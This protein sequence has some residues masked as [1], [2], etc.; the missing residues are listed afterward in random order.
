MPSFTLFRNHRYAWGLAAS[1]LLLALLLGARLK[2]VPV[3]GHRVDRGLVTMEVRGSGTLES[4][5]E[6]PVAFRVGGRI[7]E[8]PLEEGNR[9][10][11]GQVIGRLDPVEAERQLRV[12]E[13]SQSLAQSGVSRAQAELEH[14]LATRDRTRADLERARSLFKE[15]IL[16]RADLDAFVER[17]RVAEA[18]AAAL[19]EGR[20]Q[21][22][23]SVQVA[24]A[25]VAVQARNLEENILRAPLDG[26]LVKRLREP[27]H[28]VPAGTP[29][30]T[31]V[32]TRKLWV[33]AWVDETALGAMA[34]GQEAQVVFRSAPGRSFAGRVD[35][36]GR[37]VDH[38]THEFL[39]DV[40]VIEVPA[41]FA[42]GQRADVIIRPGTN[43][44]LRVPRGFCPDTGGPCWVERQGRA[45]AVPVRLGQVGENFVEVLEGLGAGDRVI[46]ARRPDRPLHQGERV[47]VQEER[48]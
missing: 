35:R 33:R 25:T 1:G 34:T 17:A 8:L 28:V 3:L 40:E 2:P 11:A 46:R 21:A 45:V 44:A 13:A 6:V 41:T 29:V 24:R 38:Q 20:T 15:G 31:L 9:V 26:I 43:A 7:L 16:S 39:V 32:S 18:Q 22:R 12:A 23:D 36:V 30:Y 19:A 5:Q 10:Q 48:S 4:V 42:V 47:S 14:T 37:Q 27:G